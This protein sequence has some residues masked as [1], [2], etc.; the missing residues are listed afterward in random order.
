MDSQ[1]ARSRRAV[2]GVN[3]AIAIKISFIPA[4]AREQGLLSFVWQK[5]LAPLQSKLESNFCC[6]TSEWLL[7]LLLL[8]MFD[9]AGFSPEVTAPAVTGTFNYHLALL[10]EKG[11][12][13]CE[14]LATPAAPRPSV[15]KNREGGASGMC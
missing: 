11:R 5:R 8:F 6:S 2:L 13:T 15:E 4:Q 9:A 3:N 14:R 12:Y 7:L 10:N 1:S